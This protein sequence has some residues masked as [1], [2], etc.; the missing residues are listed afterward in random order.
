MSQPEIKQLYLNGMTSI[1]TKQLSLKSV[2]PF[3]FSA[4]K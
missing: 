2:I 1:E 3:N 4:Q